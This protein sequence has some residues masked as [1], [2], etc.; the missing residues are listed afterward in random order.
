MIGNIPTFIERNIFQIGN[1]CLEVCQNNTFQ[2]YPEES[3]ICLKISPPSIF[4]MCEYSLNFYR[5]NI[6]DICDEDCEFYYS[7]IKIDYIS[8]DGGKPSSRGNLII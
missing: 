6:S 5:N 2:V 1:K 7:N 4:C 8:V 3:E